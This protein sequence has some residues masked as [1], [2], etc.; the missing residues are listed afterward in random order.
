MT[1]K[2]Y[3][4]LVG[5]DFSELSAR[6]LQQA[7]SLAFKQTNAE[8]HAL[9]ILPVPSSDAAQAI[10]VYAAV[11]EAGTLEIASERLRQHVQ[12]ELDQFRVTQTEPGSPFRVISHV[13]VDTAVH[14]IAELASDLG[15]DLIVIGTH[16]RS[17]IERFLLGSV[18]ESTV[19][20]ARCPVLVIP[21][22]TKSETAIKFDP[23]CAECVLAR[24]ASAGQ[25]LWCA[26]HRE[27]HGRRHTYHQGDRSGTD[28]NFPLVT[29]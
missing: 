1:N 9:S 22:E 24:K 8:V 14:G 21:A 18:A 13:S 20:H 10:S 29:Q 4:I 28:T 25:Q 5:V 3:V 6:A 23:P 11:D 17:G 27:R 12:L 19:R 16:N 15:A 26:Q 2:S 7:F